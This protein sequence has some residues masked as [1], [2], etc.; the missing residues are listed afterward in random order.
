L[1]ITNLWK[2]FTGFLVDLVDGNV[3]VRGE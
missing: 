3:D 2:A 1:P